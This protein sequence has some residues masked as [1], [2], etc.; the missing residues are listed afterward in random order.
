MSNYYPDCRTLYAIFADVRDSLT[1]VEFPENFKAYADRLRRFAI[2]DSPIFGASFSQRAKD[3]KLPKHM[4]SAIGSQNLAY[5]ARILSLERFVNIHSEAEIRHETKV[6]CW[7]ATEGT[8]T[9][10]I[11]SLLHPTA[12]EKTFEPSR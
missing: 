4:I 6:W 2:L 11:V 12:R 3:M 7:D 9:D 1:H 5:M 8:L 10:R